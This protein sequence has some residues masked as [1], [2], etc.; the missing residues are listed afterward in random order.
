ML[1]RPHFLID[2]LC[3]GKKTIRH[4]DQIGRFCCTKKRSADTVLLVRCQMAHTSSSLFA[5]SKLKIIVFGAFLLGTVS[6]EGQAMHIY[7]QNCYCFIDRQPLLL[8][9]C[10]YGRKAPKTIIFSLLLTAKRDEDL[11]DICVKNPSKL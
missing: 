8:S 1:V 7:I 4:I 10:Y 11:S 5:V 9:N 6:Y 2:G 3:N